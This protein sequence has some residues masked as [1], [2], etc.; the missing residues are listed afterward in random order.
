MIRSLVFILLLLFLIFIFWFFVLREKPNKYESESVKKQP[1]H[2]IKYYNYTQKQEDK[3]KLIIVSLT[4]SPRRI[5]LMKPVIDSIWNQTIKPDIIRINIPK[6]FKR[7]N[8]EYIIPD[9]ILNDSKIHVYQYDKDYGPIMKI[10][11]TLFDYQN[12]DNVNIIY[13]DDDVLMLPTTIEVFLKYNDD[14]NNVLCYSGFNLNTIKSWNRP[15]IECNVD[16]AEGYMS[17]FLNNNIIKKL[18]SEFSLFDYFNMVESNEFCFTSDDLLL[19]NFFNI[20]N[21]KKLKIHDQSCNFDIWW[22]SGC[23]LQ[24]GREG[25]GIMHLANDQHYS[26]YQ[27]ALYHLHNLRLNYL[28]PNYR[29]FI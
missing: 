28:L 19:S 24:Y 2:Q 22:N 3:K 8:Q 4:T 6:I 11:P 14:K 13:T 1:V 12:N 25:D 21:L 23:E 5:H 10:L 16:I 9:F 18:T 29:L 27:N 26:R 17:V 7:H 20:K 15:K